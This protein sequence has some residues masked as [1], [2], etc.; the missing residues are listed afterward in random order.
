MQSLGVVVRQVVFE[1]GTKMFERVRRTSE[2]LVLQ[3]AVES[4]DMGVV[5][6]L[7]DTGVAMQK[8]SLL[9]YMCEAS[10]ELWPV[11]CLYHLEREWSLLLS[12]CN[13]RC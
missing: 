3:R 8:L 13:E 2:T 7:P 5:V 11:V 6:A 10:T 12:P 1:R 9:E 4:L